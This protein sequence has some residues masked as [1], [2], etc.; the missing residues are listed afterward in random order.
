MPYN[1]KRSERFSFGGRQFLLRRVAFPDS[2]SP[3]WFVVDLFENAEQAAA[4]REVSAS[5]RRVATE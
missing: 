4:A 1:T 5:Q 2:P 3:E